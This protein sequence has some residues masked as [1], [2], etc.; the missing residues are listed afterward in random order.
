M[1]KDP[2]VRVRPATV[3]DKALLEGLAQFYLYDFSEIEPDGSTRLEFDERGHFQVYAFDAYWR[4]TDGFHALLFFVGAHPAGFALINTLSHRGGTVERNM[5]E[6]FVARRYRRRGV[7]REALR[8]ILA[9][10]PGQWEAAV[11]ER[12]TAAQAFWPAAIAAAPNASAIARHEGDGEHWRGP[13]WS[14]RAAAGHG[15]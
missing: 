2:A 14:F 10:Y 8:Q 9:T 15:R 7:A 1:T 6:F 3:A 5:G 11:M 13:I 4:G 12:N